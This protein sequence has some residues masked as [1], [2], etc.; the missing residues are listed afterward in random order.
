MAE[1]TVKIMFHNEVRDRNGH[2]A[3][4]P[5]KV[6]QRGQTYAYSHVIGWDDSRIN[7]E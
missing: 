7:T 5:L 4:Y 2:A 3:S 1:K 6:R